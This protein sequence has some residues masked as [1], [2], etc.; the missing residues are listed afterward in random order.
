MGLPASLRRHGVLD[1][2][3]RDQVRRAGLEAVVMP[4]LASLRRHFEGYSAS[5][6]TS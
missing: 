2:A 1:D 3:L 5:V 6:S 4:C